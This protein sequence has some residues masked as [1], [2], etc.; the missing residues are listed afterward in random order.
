MAGLLDEG[1]IRERSF[2]LLEHKEAMKRQDRKST[3]RTRP[4]LDYQELEQ[5]LSGQEARLKLEQL[6]QIENERVSE[7]EERPKIIKRLS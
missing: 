1:E 2:I 5:I 7:L 3:R 6:R 4:V